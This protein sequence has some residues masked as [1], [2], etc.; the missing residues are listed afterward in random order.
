MNEYMSKT[1][2]GVD[3]GGS[4]IT[5][6]M[7]NLETKE[8]IPATRLRI[9]VDSGAN[10]SEILATWAAFLKQA[11][12]KEKSVNRIGIAMPGPFD[13][14]TGISLIKDQAK[15]KHLYGLNVKQYLAARLNLEHHQICF[16]NDAEAFLRGELFSGEKSHI[17]RAIGLTLGTGLGSARCI[18][19]EVEDAELWCSPF[20][21]SIAED[22]LSTR[23][24]IEEY[25]R[26]AGKLVKDV[27]A[28]T[29]ETGAEKQL[30]F[31][32]FGKNL[33]LFLKEF[34]SRDRPETVILGGNI[35]NS[36]DL[37]SGELNRQLADLPFKV[38]LRPSVLGEDACLMGA[39][40]IWR[41][42]NIPTINL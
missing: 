31:D 3:I 22:Y 21:N 25:A 8:A 13:Y 17:S 30:V 15:F 24:F 41:L 40:S 11:L 10:A 20:L 34:I 16:V 12:A 26:L 18:E 36:F 29:G 39:A 37:F 42:K 1:V 2:L 38:S 4:H 14:E 28:L 27:K 6:A 35:S 33:G 7:V 23:W 19:G 32:E 9:Q 5:A